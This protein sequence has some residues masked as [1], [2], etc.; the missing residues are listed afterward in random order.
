MIPWSSKFVPMIC[1][2]FAIAQARPAPG[3]CFDDH[4]PGYY[5]VVRQTATER[6]KI[7]R[8]ESPLVL[9]TDGLSGVK[10]GLFIGADGAYLDK[11]EADSVLAETRKSVPDAYLKLLGNYSNTTGASFDKACRNCWL[12]VQD[13]KT[14]RGRFIRKKG[15]I[16]QQEGAADLVLPVGGDPVEDHLC[17]FRAGKVGWLVS[18]WTVTEECCTRHRFRVV[19]FAGTV[20]DEKVIEI[21]DG[22]TYREVEVQGDS[23]GGSKIVLMS[24]GK[25]TDE[26]AVVGAKF[27][28]IR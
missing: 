11:R 26:W 6:T 18:E 2:L 8:N 20:L 12:Q 28:K 23:A 10:N 4:L 27:V 9:S 14:I 7:D 5:V 3:F 15:W 25:T 19:S 24:N 1:G 13:G 22:P 21:D 17:V 16:L